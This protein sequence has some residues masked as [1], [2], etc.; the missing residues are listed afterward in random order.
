MT[1]PTLARTTPNGRY[2]PH[3]IIGS[4]VPSITTVTGIVAYRNLQRWHAKRAIEAYLD[5]A[6]GEMNSALDIAFG[7]NEASAR[8]D[9]IHGAIEAALMGASVEEPL[10]SRAEEM[11]RDQA[12]RFVEEWNLQPVGVEVTRFGM[13]PN[14][15]GF[16]GTAD[17]IA[18]KGDELIV[19][20]WKTGRLHAAAALQGVALCHAEYDATG[21]VRPTPAT[22]YV[23]GLSP[24][25]CRVGTPKDPER[26][27]SAF[28]ALLDAWYWRENED[29]A[30]LDVDC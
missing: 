18:L 1:Q 20:D 3:P 21:R 14:G 10:R 9:R 12:L 28:C 8:G 22:S 19:L 7:P 5:G 4:D 13:A 17:L 25:D 15:E 23:V 11:M 2:Y 24:N 6:A 16:A 30:L 29:D 26:A 27:W